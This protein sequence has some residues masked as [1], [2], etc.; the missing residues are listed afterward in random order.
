MSTPT[1]APVGG[2]G[3]YTLAVAS[4]LPNLLTGERMSDE[5]TKAVAV[6]ARAALPPKC[7]PREKLLAS[8]T[9]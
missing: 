4:S 5:Q 2:G 3:Y 6:A 8:A 9:P 7:K 1:I